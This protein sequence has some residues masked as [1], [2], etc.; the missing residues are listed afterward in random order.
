MIGTK[1]LE[2][3][4]CVAQSTFENFFFDISILFLSVMC[5]FLIQDIDMQKTSNTSYFTYQDCKREH[6]IDSNENKT[7]AGTTTIGVKT[8]IIEHIHQ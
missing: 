7:A 6:S 5:S 1:L 2:K 4:K 8:L 3:I